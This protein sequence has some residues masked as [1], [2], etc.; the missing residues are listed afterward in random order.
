MAKGFA[1]W[2]LG[3]TPRHAAARIE[4]SCLESQRCFGEPKAHLFGVCCIIRT[5]RTGHTG[6]FIVYPFFLLLSRSVENKFWKYIICR[7]PCGRPN[8]SRS[9]ASP[10]ERHFRKYLGHQEIPVLIVPR[11]FSSEIEV[12]PCLRVR[13]SVYPRRHY[14][15][16]VNDSFLV[17]TRVENSFRKTVNYLNIGCDAGFKGRGKKQGRTKAA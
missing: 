9:C 16:R 6:E 12:V 7:A 13:T 8:S 15:K 14:W 4:Q 1:I 17:S 3:R 10:A 5:R 2:R 11:M